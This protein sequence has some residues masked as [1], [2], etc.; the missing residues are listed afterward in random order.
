MVAT[1]IC[2]RIHSL[3]IYCRIVYKTCGVHCINESTEVQNAQRLICSDNTS[4][5][6]RTTR[7][8]WSTNE[9]ITYLCTLGHSQSLDSPNRHAGVNTGSSKWP[10]VWHFEQET[11]YNQG[12]RAYQRISQIKNLPS[13]TK[14][15]QVAK[16]K[17]SHTRHMLALEW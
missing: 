12:K 9:Q 14:I 13:S 11:S 16:F 10:P 1:S 8:Q 7:R 17:L 15:W 6:L 5:P 4:L 3:L 2:M